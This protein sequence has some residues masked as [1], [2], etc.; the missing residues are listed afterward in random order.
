MTT[1]AALALSLLAP[2]PALADEN[3]PVL[4]GE[5]RAEQAAL[6]LAEETGEPVPVEELL[7]E[8]RDV[9][10]NPDGTFTATEY[11]QPIRTRQ[12]GTWVDTDPT[13]VERDDG[14]LAPHASTLGLS[15][16]NGGEGPLAVLNRAGK[17][18]ALGWPTPLPEPSVDG[19]TATYPQVIPGVDLVVRAGVDGF[20]QVLVVEDADAAAQ[21]EIAELQM[22]VGVDS[23][24]LEVTDQGSVEAVDT[25]VGGAVF[26]APTPLMWDSGIPGD[27]ELSA[28][29]ADDPGTGLDPTEGPLES[30][31]IAQIGVEAD[32]DM[33]VLTPD[34]QLLQDPETNYPV[35]I[36]PVWKTSTTSAWAMVSS[37]Y[38]T[39]S[40]W[41]F[42]GSNNEGAGRCP[43]LAGDPY[44]CTNAGIKRLFYRL[45]TSA[46]AGKQILSA[47]FAVTLR[48]TYDSTGRAAQLYR[49][50][51]ITSSTTWANQP[52][53]TESLDT[54]SPVEAPISAVEPPMALLYMFELSLQREALCI[55]MATH[56]AFA[57]NLS[58]KVM[59]IF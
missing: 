1:A 16:S 48:H 26:E 20:S 37:G 29:S 7:G 32:D 40:Y 3:D 10:A 22:S 36:D 35:Y 18:L 57:S 30:S 38:R 19:E 58:T 47:E 41:K 6:E 49:T 5:A 43:Q 56:V 25:S 4:T 17:E 50:G 33:L 28:M 11:V 2:T 27:E 42:S 52:S 51:G 15:L 55:K 39:D 44:Y 8:R 54:K 24:R 53:W 21:P 34:A 45:P 23:L 59:L 9:V 46:Y 12:N 31:T 14:R 13:L